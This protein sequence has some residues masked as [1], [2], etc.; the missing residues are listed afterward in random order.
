MPMPV[1]VV[2]RE[3]WATLVVTLVSGSPRTGGVRF[4]LIA[5]LALGLGLQ[6]A[7]ARALAVPDLLAVACLAAC[8]LARAE[9]PWTRPIVSR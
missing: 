4:T 2:L 8:V 3:A 7:V 5:L 6:N 9:A 1:P